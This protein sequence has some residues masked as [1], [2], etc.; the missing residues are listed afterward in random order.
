MKQLRNNKTKVAQAGEILLGLLILTTSVSCNNKNKQQ[1]TSKNTRVVVEKNTTAN[2]EEKPSCLDKQEPIVPVEN[3]KE[4]VLEIKIVD[5]PKT[6]KTTKTEEEIFEIIKVES[7]TKKPE[8]T[9]ENKQTIVEE[10]KSENSAKTQEKLSY[11]KERRNKMEI[12]LSS[13][14][15]TIFYTITVF[16]AGA[17]IGAPL[18]NWVSA[19]LPWN[20]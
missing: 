8:I 13:T 4:E 6:T 9:V 14:L 7:I 2:E 16:V 1:L 18:W 20:K 15:G 17:L 12:I 10:K 3:I 19:K 5:E 11:N